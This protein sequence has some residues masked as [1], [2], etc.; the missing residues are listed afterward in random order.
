MDFVPRTL[1]AVGVSYERKVQ[2]WLYIIPRQ[3]L[4]FVWWYV[5]LNFKFYH[6]SSPMFSPV[7][8][9]SW[10]DR[11]SEFI[12][13]LTMK[14][15]QDCSARGDVV[16]GYGRVPELVFAIS[17]WCHSGGGELIITYGG[18]AAVQWRTERVGPLS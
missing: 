9:L 5:E 18:C 3:F 16:C 15:I 17:V 10:V 2:V 7:Q 8:C 14:D 12:V 4:S 11:G 6:C 1:V 13:W